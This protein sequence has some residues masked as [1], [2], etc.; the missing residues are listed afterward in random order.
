M[1]THQYTEKSASQPHVTVL[2][3]RDICGG[4]TGRNGMFVEV[5]ALPPI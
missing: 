4:A 3:A 5:H 2:E 1:D